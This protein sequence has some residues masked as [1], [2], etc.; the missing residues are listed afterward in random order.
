MVFDKFHNIL[1]HPQNIALN[2]TAISNNIQHRPC[3]HCDKSKIR[4]KMIPKE[5]AVNTA[6][7]KGE[8]LMIDLSWIIAE[9]V[10]KNRYWLLIMDEFT[11]ILWSYFMKTKYEQVTTIIKHIEMLKMNLKLKSNTFVTKLERNMTSRITLERDLL[12]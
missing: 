12:G 8:R 10:A 3:T 6:T 5:T 2:E 7:M 11:N 1:G 9:S 4:M